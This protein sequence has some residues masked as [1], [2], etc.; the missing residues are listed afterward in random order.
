MPRA[1]SAG[2]PPEQRAERALESASDADVRPELVDTAG[3]FIANGLAKTHKAPGDR[4]YLLSIACDADGVGELVLTL[5]RRGQEQAYGIECG[6][7]EADQFN[8]PAGAPFTVRV[9]PVEDG[10]GLILW[11]LDTVAQDAVEG[12]DDDIDGCDG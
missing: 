6:D 7:R 9:D 1:G 11:R 3:A 10:T 12:C 4:P 8:I 2:S 5:S